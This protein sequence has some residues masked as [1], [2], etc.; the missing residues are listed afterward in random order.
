MA[1]CMTMVVRNRQFQ[2]GSLVVPWIIRQ[3]HMS[4]RQSASQDYH[5]G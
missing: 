1:G 3:G 4:R 5:D 2:S